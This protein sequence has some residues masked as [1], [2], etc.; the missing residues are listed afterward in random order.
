VQGMKANVRHLEIVGNN[1]Y[2]SSNRLGYVQKC[3]VVD[4]IL[5]LKNSK[6]SLYS[7]KRWSSAYVGIGARTISVTKDGKYIF[8]AVNN[9]KKIVVVRSSD[10]KVVSK[11]NADP[12]PVGMALSKYETRLM[13]TAQGK[14][15]QGGN[16]VT[17]YSI[18]YQ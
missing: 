11:I 7:F 8:T 2:L 3:N 5:S 14:G 6:K 13:V 15:D 18:D 10:M 4:M 1:L 17:V 12:Y 9:E 16:S